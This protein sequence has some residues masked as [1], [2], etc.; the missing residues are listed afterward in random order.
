MKPLSIRLL[1]IA[2][3]LVLSLSG[4][5]AKPAT[6]T[7][8]TATTLHWLIA[9]PCIHSLDALAPAAKKWDISYYFYSYPEDNYVDYNTVVNEE[10]D[11]W[12]W[13]GGVEMGTN[14]IGGTLLEKGYLTAGWP[15]GYVSVFIYGYFLF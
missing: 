15:H 10:W 14:P 9:Q 1:A 12:L 6:G 13:Y 3:A 2:G 4:A 5:T 8:I 7:H 11:L